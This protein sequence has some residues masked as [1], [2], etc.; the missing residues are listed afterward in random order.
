MTT[1]VLVIAGMFILVGA[2]G[3]LGNYLMEKL[4]SKSG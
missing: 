3:E 4:S 2:I 1:G